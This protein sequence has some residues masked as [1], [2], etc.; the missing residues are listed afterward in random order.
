MEIPAAPVRDGES[1]IVPDP[2]GLIREM[3][4]RVRPGEATGP[5][6]AAARQ[7]ILGRA[8]EWTG[9][10]RDLP[11]TLSRLPG[12][13]GAEAF[14][15]WF[16]G[17]HQPELFHPGIW[18][19]NFVL[20]RMARRWQG[21]AVNLLVDHEET[22]SS[23]RVPGLRPDGRVE[24]REI[25]WDAPA[26]RLPAELQR[27]GGGGQLEAFPVLLREAVRP[28]VAGPLV[29]RLWPHVRELA[30]G[31]PALPHALAAARH[32]IEQGGGLETL[33]LPI[34][35]LCQTR[36]FAGFCGRIIGDA[37]RFA[38]CYNGALA[39]FRAFHRIRGQQHPFPDLAVEHGAV[40]LPL[41]LYTTADPVRRRVMAEETHGRVRL[42]APGLRREWYLDAT[43]AADS[44]SGLVGDPEVCLRPRALLLTMFVRQVMADLFVHGVGGASYDRVTDLVAARFFGSPLAPFVAATGT[45]QIVPHDPVRSQDEVRAVQQAIRRLQ[46]QPERSEEELPAEARP[47]LDARRDLTSRMNQPDGRKERQVELERIDAELQPLLRPVVGLLEARLERARVCAMD[48]SIAGSRELPFVAHPETLL[49]RLAG[50]ADRAVGGA[51]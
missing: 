9:R 2:A 21:L 14:R 8:V 41:W 5:A 25:F 29:G 43:D 17:G 6:I 16:V 51:T 10:Y 7:E 15:L 31:M 3:P 44:L 39:D 38:G 32:R 19:K 37:G 30:G 49:E 33:E 36:A 42:F 23:V 22:G 40:E 13:G 27:P 1:F 11:E 4:G 34:S 48:D 26:G 46:Q 45:W 50:A 12:S 35:R 20:D 18:W 47:L 28:W 24:W